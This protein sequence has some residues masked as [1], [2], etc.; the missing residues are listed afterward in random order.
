MMMSVGCGFLV[1]HL[2]YYVMGYYIRLLR[3]KLDKDIDSLS[4]D[5]ELVG[6]TDYGF[7]STQRIRLL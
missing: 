7:N 1:F 3:H 5:I 6:W 2:I 4:K